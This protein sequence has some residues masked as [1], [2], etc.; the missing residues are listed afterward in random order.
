LKT[1]YLVEK[2]GYRTGV[3]GRAV[4]VHEKFETFYYVKNSQYIIRC[5]RT[6][7]LFGWGERLKEAKQEAMEHIKGSGV[8]AIKYEIRKLIKN[9]GPGEGGRR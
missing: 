9:Q 3:Q 6:G 5:V 7:Y 8:G 2:D 4:Q 1:Y